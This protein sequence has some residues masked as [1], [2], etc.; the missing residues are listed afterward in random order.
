MPIAES[1]INALRPIRFRGKAR[2]LS[3]LVPRQGERTARVFGYRMRLDLTEHIQRMIY[4]GAFEREETR[5]VLRWLRPGMTVVDVGANVGYYALLAASRVGPRG[6]VFAVEPS[7]VA[8]RRLER[9][10]RENR[11]ANVRL[12]PFALGERCGEA[13]LGEPP[14]D[15]HTPSLLNSNGRG[16]MTV[17][18]RTL[19]DCLEEW[20]VDGI[21]LLKV[22]IEGYEPFMLAGGR[23]ALARG[24]VRA[25][26]CE[27]NDPWLR[28]AGSSSQSLYEMITGWGFRDVAK[29]PQWV[30]GQVV[31]C[32]FVFRG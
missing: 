15:N 30:P 20:Q 17:P 13:S 29:R 31:T 1:L 12:F 2:L 5:L 6:R 24:R 28:V 11:L 14:P 27:F 4:L 9:T 32:F 7:P 10:I 16:V 22:D 26:L 3:R 21:D 25:L 18:I 8:A 23:R 19:D